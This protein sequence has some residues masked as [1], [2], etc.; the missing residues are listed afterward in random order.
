MLPEGAVIIDFCSKCEDRVRV[1]RVRTAAAVEDC[2]WE[3]EIGGRVLWES[4]RP[5]KDGYRPMMARFARDGGRYLRRLDL[6]YTY[7]EVAPNEFRWLGGQLGLQADIKTE[8][9]RL[10]K[11]VSIAV[12]RRPMARSPGIPST[13]APADTPAPAADEAPSANG[14]EPPSTGAPPAGTPTQEP[15]PVPPEA[16]EPAEPTPMESAETG[17][18]IKPSSSNVT[19]LFDYWRSGKD[20]PVLAHFM[21]CLKLDLKKRSPTRYEC[22]EPVRGPV[23]P[24]TQVYA[25]ADWLVP[26]GEKYE[27]AAVEFV[28]AGEVRL[29]QALT[30]RGRVASPVVPTTAAAKL[31]QRGIYTLRLTRQDRVLK[32]VQVEVR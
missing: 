28:F 10:P 27:D 8:S 21:A 24:R 11:V 25:W 19:D 22:V 2:S 30:I 20:G 12:G 13:E 1:V 7:V 29:R 5:F 23:D 26:R 18:I 4:D 31:S 3:L 6:A 9:I 32:E 17:A 15:E 14:D 16:A